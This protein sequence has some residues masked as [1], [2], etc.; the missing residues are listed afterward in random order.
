VDRESSHS[1]STSEIDFF[2]EQLHRWKSMIPLDTHK[3]VDS[4]STSFDGY[5][6]YVGPLHSPQIKLPLILIDGF[7]LQ[8]SSSATVSTIISPQCGSPISRA[9]CRS[10]WWGLRDLQATPQHVRRFLLD[11]SPDRI[12][13]RPDFDLLHLYFT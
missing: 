7:L 5:D 3:K 2:L 9:M 8:M 1:V 10:M 12:P 13:S 4:E 11:G 6:Y